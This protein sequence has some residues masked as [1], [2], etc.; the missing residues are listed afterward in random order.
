MFVLL[1]GNVLKELVE[2]AGAVIYTKNFKL[3][4]PTLST[5][6]IW[7][8]EYQES[9][10]LLCKPEEKTTLERICERE[11]VDVCFIGTVTGKNEAVIRQYDFIY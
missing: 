4:D 11:K 9:N 5:L 6:E 2:P 7:G 3:G 1:S 8:A 10:A